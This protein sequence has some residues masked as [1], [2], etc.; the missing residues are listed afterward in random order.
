MSE[1]DGMLE[2]ARELRRRLEI[3]IKH[4]GPCSDNMIAE[5]GRAVRREAL[6]EVRLVL[7]GHFYQ[8]FAPD[9]D[10]DNVWRVFEDKLRAM[11]KRKKGE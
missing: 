8:Q 10:A 3:H 4:D 1:Q 9:T 5:F 2:R 6:E 7:V 11:I